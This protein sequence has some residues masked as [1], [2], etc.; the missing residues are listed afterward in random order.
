[1]ISF[2]KI[3]NSA[4]NKAFRGRVASFDPGETT[5]SALFYASDTIELQVSKQLKTWPLESAVH[6]LT[7]HL[8]TFKP[9]VVV[10]ESYRVYS[11]KTDQH[12]NSD[13]PTIQ[14]IGCLKTLCI[15]QNIPFIQQSAQ[16]A[17]Q[18]VTDDKLEQWGFYKV[19]E[20]HSRD[21]I[22]H[23][24]YYLLFGKPDK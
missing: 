14:I 24:C 2:D 23:G 3:R 8:L 22:R 5:G 12:S 7:Q 21:A 13:I 1:M 19:G 16:V 9:D 11:W 10:M 18:F 17:K 4:P 20:R 6:Q 15:Q